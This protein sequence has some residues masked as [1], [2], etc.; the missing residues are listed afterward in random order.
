MNKSFRSIFANLFSRLL[1]NTTKKKGKSF[2]YIFDNSDCSFFVKQS[3]SFLSLIIN[4]KLHFSNS[5]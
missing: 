5:F 1:P 3:Y 2:I 4:L